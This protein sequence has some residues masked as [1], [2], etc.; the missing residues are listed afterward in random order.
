MVDQP[1]EFHGES[2]VW[3]ALR[4]SLS[5]SCVV[6]N[7]REV[8]G[9]EYDFCVLVD[10]EGLLVIEVKGWLAGKIKVESKDR[11]TIDG[12]AGP[13]GSPKRQ[14]RGYRFA[15]LNSLKDRLNIS[16]L[17]LDMVCY[18]FISHAEYLSTGLEVVSE[19]HLTLLRDDIEDPV[20]LRAKIAA[21]FKDATARHDE[22]TTD[23]RDSIRRW[24][25]PWRDG[26]QAVSE[27]RP[28]SRLTAS[29]QPF[30]RSSIDRI[31][32]DYFAG[33]KQVVFLSREN[34]YKAVVN[35]LDSRFRQMDVQ[36]LGSSLVPGWNTGLKIGSVSTMTFNFQAFLVDG[37]SSICPQPLSVVDGRL[38]DGDLDA[39]AGLADATPFNLQQYLV[40]HAPIDKDTLVR[41]GAGTGKTF[42]MVSRVA[43]LCHTQDNPISDISEELAMVTFTNDAAMNMKVRLK[44]MFESYFVLCRDPKYLRFVA[45]VDNSRISTIHSFMI[46]LLRG[47]P[48]LTGMGV[49]F[50]IAPDEFGR[51]K[52]YDALIEEFL[53][54]K[55]DGDPGFGLSLSVPMYELRRKLIQLANKL[56]QK[57]IDLDAITA[58]DLG[59]SA[60]RAI[61]YFNE[62]IQ[63][64]LIPAEAAH[65]ASMRESNMLALEDCMTLLGRVMD[66]NPSAF[67]KLRIRH[68]FIDEFQ[69]TDSAQIELF[70]KIQRRSSKGCRLFVVGD[71]KQS[72]Y[73]FRGATQNAFKDLLRGSGRWQEFALTTNYRTDKGLLV[74]LNRVFENMGKQE[75]LPY[76][77]PDRLTSNISTPAPE[78]TRLTC[79]PYHGNDEDSFDDTLLRVVKDQSEFAKQLTETQEVN[80]ADRTVAILC[81]SNWQV[82]SVVKAGAKRG[83][84][85]ETNASGDL[86]GLESTLD[87]YRLVAALLDNSNPV[88]LAN[89]IE[90]N[91]VDL[92]LDF[93]CYRGTP[94]ADQVQDLTRVLDEFMAIRT[95]RTWR[96]IIDDATTLSALPA[97]R[98]LFSDLQPWRTYS[99]D[100]RAQRHYIANYEYL[101]ELLVDW[102]SN[103]CP[104]LGRIADYLRVNISTNQDQPSRDPEP[105]GEG[106]RVLCTT[107]HMSKGLEYGTVILPFAQDDLIRSAN[108][109]VIVNYEQGK[110]SYLVGFPDAQGRPGIQEYNTNYDAQKESSEQLKEECRILYVA[111]TR[112][113]RNC[114]WMK[115]LDRGPALDWAGLLEE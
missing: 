59:E 11:I 81:R 31:L 61:P 112:A 95:G 42:S 19:E 41:A 39:L 35:E 45:D 105:P 18:P 113:I 56:K 79:S 54:K 3:E 1:P 60:S 13:Q 29:A 6:Y 70:K 86:Y 52:L 78:G 23:V 109:P 64:V 83:V 92:K 96:E 2:K 111:L 90:S 10:G 44:Q 71:P 63:D 34:D 80:L 75:Y 26:I 115:N 100:P 104:S 99:D 7:N 38:L 68:L 87:L 48:L 85:I 53:Q 91:Y 51:G 50:S 73:R 9:R 14:A 36:P 65:A 55:L 32:D 101:I 82:E 16:P 67:A 107:V 5:D 22:F 84:H 114:V 40:E 20:R 110:L 57:S 25:E 37:L 17:V 27:G 69:D 12:Y 72:I 15:I 58:S 46:D 47:E 89:L 98:R 74:E 43:F 108:Q 49:D 76:S 88:A 30:A 24:W 94:R 106:V 103:Q 77:E 4:T 62:L 102:M 28:Y 33:T 93:R 8:N 97:L 66:E 21:L